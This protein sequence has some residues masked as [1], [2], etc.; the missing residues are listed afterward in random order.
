MAKCSELDLV[1]EM[2]SKEEALEAMVEMIREYA[3]DYK[4]REDVY[5]RSPNRAHHK[6]YIDRIIVCGDEWELMELIEI[7]Y[8]HLHV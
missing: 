4:A 5:L 7:R 2:D 8:G 1:T 3:E 6:P